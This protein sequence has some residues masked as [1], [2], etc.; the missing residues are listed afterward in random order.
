MCAA[1]PIAS[2]KG[3]FCRIVVIEGNESASLAESSRSES[4]S[5]D[6][7]SKSQ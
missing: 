6:A 2:T 1:I 7:A 3:A 5:E 4:E